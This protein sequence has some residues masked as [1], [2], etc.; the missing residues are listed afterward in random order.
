MRSAT[1]ALGI[2]GVWGL[3][4]AG[5]AGVKHTFDDQDAEHVWKAMVAVAEQP[6]YDDWTIVAND[7]WVNEADHRIEI[8]RRLGR[9]VY[10]NQAKPRREQRTWQFEVRLLGTDPPEAT[11]ASRN[12]T[13]P[14]QL[15]AEASRYFDDV[16]D[17][18]HGWPGESVFG[19]R[20]QDLLDS[21]G[22]DEEGDADPSDG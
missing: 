5:C 21:L 12:T 2:V 19:P 1:C 22:L 13:V 17:L 14:T 6:R 16:L 10:L 7:V 18:L 8:H 4:L 11:F 9:Q 15:Q 20:D 3:A